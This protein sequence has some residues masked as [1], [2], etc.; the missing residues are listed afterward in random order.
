MNA[1]SHLKQKVNQLSKL[2]EEEWIDFS[3]RWKS[4]DVKKGDYIIQVGQV[5]RYFYFVHEGMLRAFMINNGMDVSVGFTYDGDFSG[6]YDSFLEQR[7]ADWSMQATTNTEL[8]RIGYSDLMEMFDRYKSVERWGRLF[9]AQALI[10]IARRQVEVRSFSAEERF[11]RLFE[12]SPHIFQLVSQKHLASY[13]G[14]T[15]ETFSRMRKHRM[16]KDWQ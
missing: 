7:P 11:D 6:A 9:N 12:Q 2:T 15:P 8:L 14:M 5:E 1:L 10:G 3:S 16:K 4:M 13:V